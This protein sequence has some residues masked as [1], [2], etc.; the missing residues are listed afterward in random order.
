MLGTPIRWRR[1]GRDRAGTGGRRPARRR[2]RAHRF[3]SRR[4]WAC[5]R[6][7]RRSQTGPE[8]P[9]DLG[10]PGAPGRDRCDRGRARRR[11]AAGGGAGAAEG[12]AGRRQ[13]R[14]PSAV[15]GQQRRR[16]LRAPE[17]LAHGPV[18]PGGGTAGHRARVPGD[19]PDHRRAHRDRRRRRLRPQ[20]TGPGIR[21]R[22]AVPAPLQADAARR[23]DRRV[24]AVPAVGSGAEGRP[25]HPVVRRVHP[26]GQG[27]RDHP[28]RAAGIA[29]PVGRRDTLRR[30]ARAVLQGRCRRLAVAVRRGQARG[31]RRPA[32]PARGFALR[33][34]AERQGWQ[35]RAARPA[36]AVLDRQVRVPGRGRHPAGR[37]RRA[38]GRRGPALR[39]GAEAALDHPLLAALPGRP[40]ARSA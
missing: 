7:R 36:H 6:P 33:R 26:P 1:H 38:H 35:G 40:G 30:V 25:F 22:P 24:P 20:R 28:H 39:Q 18:D 34:R 23:A 15:R 9:G 27:R 2:P 19:Q 31:I 37:P 10:C 16:R 17:R 12:R 21:R 13:R 4:P 3:R 11:P 29:L 8:R 14:D 5:R 32:P